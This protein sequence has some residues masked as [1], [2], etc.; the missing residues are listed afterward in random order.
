MKDLKD[1][2]TIIRMKTLSEVDPGLW[3]LEVY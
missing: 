3:R 2:I 1:L